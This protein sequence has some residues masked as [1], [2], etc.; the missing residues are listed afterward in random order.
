[1]KLLRPELIKIALGNGDVL[2][3]KKRLTAGEELAMQA[4]YLIPRE[5]NQPPLVDYLKIGP[6]KILAYL[7]ELTLTDMHDQVITLRGEPAE[8]VAATLNQLDGV[9]YERVKQ[10]IVA[11]EAA[12]LAEREAEK[13]TPS[14]SPESETI[15][16]LPAGVGGGTSGYAISSSPHT[17]S[18]WNR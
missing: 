5:D 15:S 10:A 13:K 8:F 2:T 7:V 1:M 6:A 4:R 3:V 14:I 12:M 9:D 11:H 17:N 18:S 16:P